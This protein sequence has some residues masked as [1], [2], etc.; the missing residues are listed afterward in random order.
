MQET[1]HRMWEA[2]MHRI[3]GE[4]LLAEKSADDFPS[5]ESSFLRALKIAKDQGAKSL[6]LRAAMS[7]A[8]LWMQQGKQSEALDQLV[9]VYN[10]FTEG[11]DTRDLKDAKAMI[12]E[13]SL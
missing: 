6:E 9:D 1:D 13:M 10:W 4:L 5:A 11:F 12:A 7:I 3:R 8:R 2:E